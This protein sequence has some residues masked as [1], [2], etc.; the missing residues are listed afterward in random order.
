LEQSSRDLFPHSSAATENNTTPV[1][2]VCG[3]H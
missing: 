1:W 2:L 3:S